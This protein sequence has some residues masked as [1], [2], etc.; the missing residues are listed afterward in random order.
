MRAY[1]KGDICLTWHCGN[2]AVPSTGFCTDCIPAPRSPS[3][4]IRGI[5]LVLRLVLKLFNIN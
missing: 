2:A 4:T 1:V 5:R 3:Y